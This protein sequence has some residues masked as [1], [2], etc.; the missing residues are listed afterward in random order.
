[1]MRNAILRNHLNTFINII[2]SQFM[3]QLF[4][5][6]R[7]LNGRP[8]SPKTAC[9]VIIYSTRTLNTYINIIPSQFMFQLFAYK[10]ALNT[11][12]KHYPFSI[13]V[14]VICLHARTLNTYILNIIIPSQFMYQLFNN[15]RALLILK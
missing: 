1:M 3:Y 8:S 11:Y 10:R 9:C 4:A 14:S 2:P 15:T 5:Y 13:H 7:T 6:T 12:Y